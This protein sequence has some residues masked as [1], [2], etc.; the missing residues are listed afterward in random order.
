MRENRIDHKKRI[1]IIKGDFSKRSI[2][3][4]DYIVKVVPYHREMLEAFTDNIPFSTDTPIRIIELGCGT[5]L[6]TQSILKKYPNARLKCLDMS[7]DM[8]NLAKKRFKA[9]PN[10]EFILTDYSKF[11]FQEECDA[12]VSFLSLMYLANDRTRKS[13]FKKAYDMLT[14]KGVFVSGEMNISRNKHFQEVYMEKWIQHMR[15]SYSDDFI[16]SEVLEKAKIH[17]SPA[18]LADEIRYLKKIGF[19]QVEIAW[20]Y[21]G[22]SV[23][24]A[25]K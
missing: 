3:Y 11:K 6:A 23:Y 17:G 2:F 22:F 8:L 7:L 24:E 5:G 9:F 25:I 15:K 4:D 18:V 21:Y 14:S 16:Q 12:V 19:N 1:D 13:V 10:I 20:K